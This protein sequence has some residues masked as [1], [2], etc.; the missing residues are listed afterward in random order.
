MLYQ[1][2]VI[3]QPQCTSH[4]ASIQPMRHYTGHL[5]ILKHPFSEYS[6]PLPTHTACVLPRPSGRAG[7]SRSPRA[8]AAA[9]PPPPR[10]EAASA[11]PGT[12]RA[13]AR[14]ARGDSAHPPA[15]PS[16]SPPESLPSYGSSCFFHTAFQRYSFVSNS[17]VNPLGTTLSRG[18]L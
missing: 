9:P 6:Q 17:P 4:S 10:G 14:P 2:H 12:Q 16:V 3:H 5:Q 15:R 11:G 1:H 7:A 18:C 8:E 13:G